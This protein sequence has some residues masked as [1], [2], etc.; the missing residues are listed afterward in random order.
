M[1]PL[2]SSFT[3]SF[4]NPGIEAGNRCILAR[5][6]LEKYVFRKKKKI[7]KEKKMKRK[8]SKTMGIEVLKKKPL[9]CAI[10]N[11]VSLRLGG[12]PCT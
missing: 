3:P 8:E 12:V 5:M 6:D 2:R 11:P 7:K 10:D 4:V 9:S 1:C